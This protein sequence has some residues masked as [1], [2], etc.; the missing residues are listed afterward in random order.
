M[1]AE[2]EDDTAASDRAK[3][4]VPESLNSLDFDGDGVYEHLESLTPENKDIKDV[5][6]TFNKNELEIHSAVTANENDHGE[7]LSNGDF[8]LLKDISHPHVD[9]NEAEEKSHIAA[10]CSTDNITKDNVNAGNDSTADCTTENIVDLTHEENVSEVVIVGDIVSQVDLSRPLEKKEVVNVDNTNNVECLPREESV[11]V[12]DAECNNTGAADGDIIE[13]IADV[14]ADSNE[15]KFVQA[16]QNN[17]EP[18]VECPAPLPSP[19]DPVGLVENVEEASKNVVREEISREVSQNDDGVERTEVI[20]ESEH[21]LQPAAEADDIKENIHFCG[22]EIKPDFY[23]AGLL[24][25]YLRF[26]GLC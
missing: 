11:E 12:S 9:R 22:F 21:S 3:T 5:S 7:F 24:L 20:T 14:A 10:A 4:P 25:L 18:R 16:E 15:D 1:L 26:F 17:E 13:D 6:E 19:S 8:T 23:F 2:L